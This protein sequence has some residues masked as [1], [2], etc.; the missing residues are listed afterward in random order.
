MTVKEYQNLKR[1]AEEMKAAAERAAGAR[2][3][4]LKRI[5]QEFG[6]SNLKEARRLLEKMQ[7][8]IGALEADFHKEVEK[9]KKKWSHLNESDE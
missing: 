1:T 5:K 6:C 3:S 7:G 9:L 2:E 4:I 8:K